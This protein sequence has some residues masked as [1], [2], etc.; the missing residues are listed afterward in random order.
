M[1]AS[2]NRLSELGVVHDHPQTH[3]GASTSMAFFDESNPHK[4]NNMRYVK[5]PEVLQKKSQLT[6]LEINA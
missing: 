5:I 2:L 3:T 6:T 4:A 1:R